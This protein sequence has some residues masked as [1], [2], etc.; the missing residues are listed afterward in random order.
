L[1][2]CDLNINILERYE[3]P[4]ENILGL[5]LDYGG[6]IFWAVSIYGPNMNDFNFFDNLRR[7]VSGNGTGSGSAPFIIGGDWNATVCTL[8]SPDNID[9]LNMLNPP[10]HI[11]SQKIDELMQEGKLTDPFR[12]LWPEKRDFTYIP[13]TGRRNRSR[14]DFF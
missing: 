5:K 10:S 13:R 9:I 2:D 11:R 7:L 1:I 6:Y 12:A 8:N 4:E 14:L 3:D